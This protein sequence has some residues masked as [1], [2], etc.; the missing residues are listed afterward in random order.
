[1]TR[2]T[3]SLILALTLGGACIA[4]ADV[5]V[6]GSIRFT[7]TPGY[8]A[9]YEGGPLN[10]IGRGV[11]YERFNSAESV[12]GDIASGGGPGFIYSRSFAQYRLNVGEPGNPSGAGLASAAVADAVWRDIV[13]SGPAGPAMVPISINVFL[14]GYDILGSVGPN[15]GTYA[16][17]YAS[18]AARI[19]NVVVA[20]GN[21]V[22]TANGGGPTQTPI[23]DGV[24]SGFTGSRS[25]ATDT[26]MVPVNTSFSLSIQL[27]TAAQVDII[28]ETAGTTTSLMNFGDTASLA[29]TGPAFNVPAGYTVNSLE[30]R[31][32]NNTFVPCFCDVDHS[33]TVNSQDFFDFLARFFGGDADFNHDGF[34]SSQDF[35]DFLSCFF[36]GC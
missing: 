27:Q 23:A 31:V 14:D 34:T 32:T 4:H 11:S 9:G 7:N 21:Y 2:S 18:F 25:F 1:M 13:V 29:I 33:G 26:V 6:S 28:F 30:A 16:S 10:S 22:R 35:F 17:A 19:N 8:L 5:T 15:T 24:F 36:A 20:S 12:L 3:V